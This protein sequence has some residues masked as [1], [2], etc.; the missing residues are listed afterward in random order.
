M[1]YFTD[2]ELY[3]ILYQLRQ[4]DNMHISADYDRE[5]LIEKLEEYFGDDQADDDEC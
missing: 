2:T 5:A 1:L 3:E 4:L